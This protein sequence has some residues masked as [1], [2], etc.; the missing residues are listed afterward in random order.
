V[1]ATSLAFYF[2]RLS[3]GFPAPSVISGHSLGQYNAAVA[4]GAATIKD[5][6][7]GVRI[8][9]ELLRKHAAGRIASVMYSG[10]L[11]P[12]DLAQ[13]LAGIRKD[14]EVLEVANINYV[15]DDGTQIVISGTAE[16]MAARRGRAGRARRLQGE[17]PSGQ[18]GLPLFTR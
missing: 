13:R 2:A 12:E 3:E 6:M 11:D 5:L 10:R 7:G 14:G 17:D 1:A 15:T 18:R 16:A 9:G 8:R 4:A